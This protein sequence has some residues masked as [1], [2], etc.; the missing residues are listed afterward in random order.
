MSNWRE[1]L[2]EQSESTSLAAWIEDYYHVP[3]LVIL[4][5]F[6]LWNRVRNYGNFIVDGTVYL[7]GNDPWYHLRMTEYTV[8]NFP[9]TMA[10]DPWTYFPIGSVP[11]QF[12]TLFN[13]LIAF[14]ALVLGL[15]SPSEG[16]VEQVFLV[17]PPFVALLVC[18]PGYVIGRRLGGRI[19]G[20]IVVAT[21]ALM[22]DRFLSVTLAGVVD[23]HGIEVLFMS[24]SVLGMM[25]AL[26]ATEKEKPVF[27]LLQAREFETM[28]KT[29]GYSMLAGVAMAMYVWTWPPA[30][31]IFGIFSIFFVLQMSL[32]HLRGRSPEH[33]AFVGVISMVTAGILILSTTRTLDFT[34]VTSRS[35]LQ[36]GLAF[37]GAGGV[38]FLAV[39][40][41]EFDNRNLRR[42]YY[43]LSIAG[44]IVL[45][46]GVMALALPG[47]FDFFTSQIN[48]IFGFVTAPGTTAGTIGEARPMEFSELR[49]TYQLAFFTAIGGAVLLLI[50][51]ILDDEPRGE[52]LLI[53][54]WGVM[55]VI[56]TLTQ[57]RFAYYLTIVVGALN[58]ALV[59][60]IF[61][62]TGGAS[63]EFEFETYQVLTVAV[64]ILV[65]FAPLAGLPII[66][67]DTTATEFASDRSAPGDVVAWDD[68]LQYMNENTPVPGQFGA[69]DN[70]PMELFG[71]YEETDDFEYQEGSYGV[72]S[73][74]DYGHWITER[75]E[76]IPNANPFQE[77]STSAAEFL[78]AQ[79]EE[80]ALDVLSGL[81]DGEN[82]QTRYVMIDWRMVET[83][84][85]A[86]GKFFAP[87]Q[88][89]P[90]YEQQ[91]FSTQLMNV[92]EQGQLQ[93][94][95]RIH[96]QP[97]YNSMMTRLYHYHGSS[98]SP[99]PVVVE[100]TGQE[101]EFAQEGLEDQTYIEA[102]AETEGG[103]VEMFDS[104]TEA[105]DYV[106]NTTS[107]QV[108]GIGAMPTERVDG[109]EHFRLVHTSNT[110]AIPQSEAD[111]QMMNYGVNLAMTQVFQQ[112][113]WNTGY[114]QA[115]MEG[116]DGENASQQELQQQASLDALNRMYP[117]TPSFTKTFERVP[118]ATIEGTGPEN[119]SV[120]VSVELEPENGQ[121]FT[122]SRQ[123][124]TD[125]DGNFEL[126][127][128][129]ATT[130]YDEYGV[131]E[132]YTEPAVEATGPYQF[133]GGSPEQTENGTLLVWQ[134]SANVTE[135]Q[136]IGEDTEPVTV[137]IEQEELEFD[138]MTGNESDGGDG[139]QSSGESDS[140]SESESDE[141][142]DDTA[143]VSLPTEQVAAL[144]DAT[145]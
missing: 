133:N 25:V 85:N 9:S 47:L 124:T 13:Q 41:R 59:G 21:I 10:Y 144:V 66:S 82:A 141:S 83:E 16:L 50:K 37:L 76:R 34:N 86:G 79:D 128:P 15:G 51:Q 38:L 27:E 61:T 78:L 105:R 94:L 35:L 114:G 1:Q 58:A 42:A 28:R 88:F 8:E 7:S 18:I 121:P 139:E 89:H 129:Y 126:V 54:L 45:T 32:D 143:S 67:A 131:E 31:W 71:S 40:S 23:H 142:G 91:D 97:Y 64:I 127:V 55:M 130:G 137:E 4:V 5:G 112:N 20:L 120:Q 12:G 140:Q 77:G 111:Q 101:R 119:S 49:E 136:V 48:R 2:S 117:T 74:W 69:P 102:P 106:D 36:P 98:Q 118:G 81:Q 103:N 123:A 110:S 132:G 109:L 30:M 52:E 87:P 135:G 56:A 14:V 134:G 138:D 96:K 39:L 70:E 116:M 75:G 3:M 145:G 29:I 92:G 113:T 93:P 122:Y 57:L 99:E 11:Q 22:P 65:M 44:T 72:M 17:A 26:S 108:G 24:L 63:K 115:I 62:L 60:Y 84:S 53:V 95:A 68:S 73:W 125:D 107:A 46:A 100:W 104:L 19:G 43:P 90:E 80:E 33:A 6:I